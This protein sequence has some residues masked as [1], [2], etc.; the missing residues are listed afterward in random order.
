MGCH[1]DVRQ[2]SGFCYLLTGSVTNCLPMGLRNVA[3]LYNPRRSDLLAHACALRPSPKFDLRTPPVRCGSANNSVQRHVARD[4]RFGEAPSSEASAV[5]L[6]GYRRSFAPEVSSQRMTLVR[7]R[8]FVDT[9]FSLF[10]YGK[11]E[12]IHDACF[13]YVYVAG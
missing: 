11:Q 13:P 5:W 2:L 6:A 7:G 10:P 1:F 8:V 3:K 12:P 9:S 4:R